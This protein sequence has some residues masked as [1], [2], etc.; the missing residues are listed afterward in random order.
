MPHHV[1]TR[2]CGGLL[3]LVITLAA[4]R[5]SAQLD[6]PVAAQLPIEIRPIAPPAQ[7]LPEEAATRRLK[8]VSFIVY[9]DTRGGTSDGVSV[10]PVHSQVMDRIL[11]V[12]RLRANT[13]RAIRFVL[14][15][16]DAVL[17]G[18]DVN[19]WNVSY[20]PVI[21][22]LTKAAGIPYFLTLGNHDVL[23][24]RGGGPPS[25]RD[26]SLRAMSQL[27]PLVGSARRLGTSAS[28]AFGIGPL[29][30]I[31]IDSNSAADPEQLAWVSAQLDGLDRKRFK[32]IAAFLH[33][34]P[35]TSGPH[36]G[37]IIE[38]ET[39]A[40]RSNWMP[41]F[42]K[43]RVRLVL[44]GHEHFYEHWIERY[45]DG[46]RSQRMDILVTGGGGAPIYTY[47]AEPDLTAY[48]AEGVTTRLRIEHLVKPGATI[49]ANPNHFVILD[50]D[51]DDV[52]AEVVA[53]GERPYAPFNGKTRVKLED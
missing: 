51:G 3:C 44:A 10:H 8:K 28:Y 46:S 22:R 2:L 17:R 26:V 1:A 24:R 37:A 19:M 42:R 9:G 11:E 16:G 39:M 38:P 50:V 25:G 45:H 21:E 29:F 33:H 12:A 15:T 36:G 48:L 27:Y 41:L 14:Q 49:D 18:S 47:R 32:T 4:P 30:I 35:Y 7:A 53:L 5:V 40:V 52:R 43:H 34:P 13:D 31:A 20:T 23:G 6:A